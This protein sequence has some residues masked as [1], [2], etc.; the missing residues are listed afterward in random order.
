MLCMEKGGHSPPRVLYLG[1]PPSL[2]AGALPKRARST[3]QGWGALSSAT[4]GGVLARCQPYPS[5]ATPLG[6]WRIWVDFAVH[7]GSSPI[8]KASLPVQQT[9]RGC[10]HN[11]NRRDKMDGRGQGRWLCWG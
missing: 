8:N 10:F 3:V 7:H 2:G 1:F 9:T 6:A 11:R 4:G 5:P